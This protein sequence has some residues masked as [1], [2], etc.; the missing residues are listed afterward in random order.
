MTLDP[1]TANPQLIVSRDRKSVRHSDLPVVL[2]N[3][4]ERFDMEL[5]VLG[6]EGLCSG[7]HCWVVDV[8]RGRNWAVGI[9]RQSV[10]RKGCINLSPEQGIWAVEQCWGQFKALTS[11]WTSLS[12]IRK[13]RRIRVSL[14]YER[15]LVA[16][17]DADLDVPVFSFPPVSFKHEKIYPWLWVGPGSHL[18]IC[19]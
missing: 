17:F 3:N 15:G 4:P 18:S 19:L 13:P 8:E 16:F 11:H 14:D 7:R 2:P 12:L 10:K 1:Q 5:F 9:A 6:C